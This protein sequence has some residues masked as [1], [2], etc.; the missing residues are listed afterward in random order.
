MKK[1]QILLIGAAGNQG[2]EYYNLL[3]NEVLFT[4]MVDSAFQKL[5][6]IYK[7]DILLFSSVEEALSK[8]NFDI[9]VVCIPHNL[10]FNV[11]SSLL[12][13]NKM[14]VKEKPFALNKNDICKYKKL[15]STPTIFTI[16]QRQFNP[17][18]SQAIKDIDLIGAI[19]HYKYEYFLKISEMTKGWR[20][21]H[22]AAGGG[23][24]IDMGYHVFDIILSFWG[25]P[26]KISSSFS[27]CYDEMRNEKLEDTA[28]ILFMHKNNLSGIIYLNRHHH[29]KNESLEI[30]GSEGTLVIDPD[31]YQIFDRHGKLVKEQKN[32]V[33]SSD[34]K[35]I[36]FLEYLNNKDNKTFLANHIQHHE[37]IVDVIDALYNQKK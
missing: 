37:N 9:A 16:V 21:E 11:T 30:L 34:I 14:I 27:Y 10:H 20:A 13:A 15:N 25:V 2:Q 24:I 8:K 31:K 4:G 33:N 17:I 29:K 3:K 12:K 28:S 18:F 19:Y 35:K 1:H 6:T 22:R 32:R 26:K 36:M 7:N 23:V 5:K